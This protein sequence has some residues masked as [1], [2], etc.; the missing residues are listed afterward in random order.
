MRGE[1]EERRRASGLS[2]KSFCKREKKVCASRGWSRLAARRAG[3]AG[4]LGARLGGVG[5]H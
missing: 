2:E 5:W 4:G 1:R 3:P